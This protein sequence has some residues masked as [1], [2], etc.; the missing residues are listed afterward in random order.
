[1]L[2][3]VI[4]IFLIL[5][6]FSLPIAFSMGI[7][8]LV[9]MIWTKDFLMVIPQRIFNGMDSFVLLAVPFFILAGELMEAGGISHRLMRL[10]DSLVGH[11]R[12]GLGMVAVVAEIFFSGIS[13]ST[14]ADTAAMASMMAPAMKESGYPAERAAAIISASCGMGILV[15]PCIAMVVYGIV[16]NVSIAALFAAGFL[17]AFFMA[18]VIMVLIYIQ[19]KKL[20]LTPKPR[21]SAKEVLSAFKSS[22]LAL[23]MPII[24]FGGILG[25]I[26]TTT[27]A[28]VIAVVYGLIVGVFIYREVTWKQVGKI[29]INTVSVTGIVL[30]LIGV[31]SVFT[32][33]LTLQQVPQILADAM[34]KLSKN[35]VVFLVLMNIA[36]LFIGAILEGIPA[37]IMFTPIF[38][39]IAQ[40][41]GVDPVHFGILLIANMGIG[42]FLPPVGVNFFIA[43]SIADAPITQGA[44]ALAPYLA[45]M[46]ATVILITFWPGIVLFLPKILL[47]Y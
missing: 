32:W 4:L 18:S 46:F 9:G 31:A 45:I 1:M 6:V 24:I 27:E 23:L 16:A 7:A 22:I 41:L 13:G 28:A 15:P 5:I 25:G 20:R 42:V 43:C 2:T 44:R 38:L 47:G 33:L 34:L 12:G 36:F 10:A 37:L 8:S 21:S 11:L 17:P 39:P 40:K 19:A 30:F 14:S 35:P 26:T 29:L 3:T